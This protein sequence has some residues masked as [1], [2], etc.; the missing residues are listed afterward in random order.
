ML[1][2]C[3]PWR[4]ARTFHLKHSHEEAEHLGVRGRFLIKSLPLTKTTSM[5]EIL[6]CQENRRRPLGK[7]QTREY[8]VRG[9]KHITTQ[10][11]CQTLT[12]QPRRKE[13][14]PTVPGAKRRSEAG[15]EYQSPQGSTRTSCGAHWLPLSK[16]PCHSL[17]QAW[18]GHCGRSG[19]W[20]VQVPFSRWPS[21]AAGMHDTWPE[22]S[23]LRELRTLRG[24]GLWVC[25]IKTQSQESHT[26]AGT[27]P[28]KPWNTAWE[29]SKPQK[30]RQ[31]PRGTWNSQNEHPS[32]DEL[33]IPQEMTLQDLK[34]RTLGPFKSQGGHSCMNKF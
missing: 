16:G 2:L 25:P 33:E 22:P 5:Q 11:K 32:E 4:I 6:S 31:K 27:G 18:W 10:E 15:G 30:I 29:K 24:P 17:S 8:G 21:D 9:C 1:S 28:P 7:S 14:E 3:F 13:Q 19:G 23:S 34:K 12:T 26:N 20:G